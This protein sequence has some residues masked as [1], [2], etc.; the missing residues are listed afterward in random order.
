M[1]KKVEK[2]NYAE[3]NPLKKK[4]EEKV[5]HKIQVNEFKLIASR[6]NFKTLKN[7]DLILFILFNLILNVL[8]YVFKKKIIYS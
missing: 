6:I 8:E 1:K 3:W 2:R 5:L 7:N 4:T